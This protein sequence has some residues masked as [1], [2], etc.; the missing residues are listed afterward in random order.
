MRDSLGRFKKGMVPWNIGKKGFRPSK[1]TE[2]KS[3][4]EHTGESHPSWK[5]GVQKYKKDCVHLWGGNG[6]RLRRPKFV[7]EHYHGPIPKGYVIYHI[8]GDKNND[9]INNLE[10]I[11][12]AELLK[13]NNT[14]R[15]R[16]NI[17]NGDQ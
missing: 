14:S 11:S 17:K 1:E 10:A 3:G 9:D 7:Y 8:D 6:K 16:H 12:R 4:P 5:G 15:L 2:F 13:R